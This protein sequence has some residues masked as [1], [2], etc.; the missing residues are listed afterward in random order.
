MKTSLE[1]S[2]YQTSE[3]VD[4][5]LISKLVQMDNDYFP[6]PWIRSHWKE[7]LLRADYSIHLAT[8]EGQLVGYAL[9]S[10]I[11]IE[12]LAHLLK[13]VVD[14]ACEGQNFATQLLKHS[15]LNLSKKGLSGIYLEVSVKND[16]AI[17]LYEKLEFKQLN[18]IKNFYRDSVDAFAMRK[19]L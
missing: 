10:E 15:F 11:Q 17:G 3:L 9:Y 7:G 19:E 14:P 13:V 5:Q 2:S 18:R 1:I 4:E 12:E 16:K 6:T 8:L